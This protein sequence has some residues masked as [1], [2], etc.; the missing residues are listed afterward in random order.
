MELKGVKPWSQDPPLGPTLSYFI[1]A[2]LS[3]VP[4]FCV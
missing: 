4:S 2:T 3:F 1:K